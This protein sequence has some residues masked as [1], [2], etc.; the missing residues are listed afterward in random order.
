MMV[1]VR[2]LDCF[3]AGDARDF[4]DQPKRDLFPGIERGSMAGPSPALLRSFEAAARLGGLTRAATELG[5]TPGAVGHAVR[6]LE[7]WAGAPLLRREGRKL[8]PTEPALRALPGLA[9]AAD[10][11][12]AGRLVPAIDDPPRLTLPRYLALRRSPEP[13]PVIRRL[14]RFLKEAAV[15]A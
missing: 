6:A 5:V 13:R 4:A 8:I 14:C 12:R 3:S 9:M 1:I 7:A 11:L 15:D 10:A 2:S